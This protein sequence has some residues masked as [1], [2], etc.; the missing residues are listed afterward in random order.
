MK[1]AFRPQL[2]PTIFTIPSIIILIMLGTWQVERLQW[3]NSQIAEIKMKSNNPP[4][5]YLGEAVE[6]ETQQYM[7]FNLTGTFQHEKEKHLYTGPKTMKGTPGYNIF[8]PLLLENGESVLVDRGWVPKDKKSQDQR[9]ETLTEGITKITAMLHRGEKPGYFTPENDIK[10][11]LWFWAD[12]RLMLENNS[13]QDI[14]FREL[15][16]ISRKG[17]PIA[18][19]TQIKK[20]NDHL[21]Y[22]ITWYSLAIILLVIY[23][24]FH[25]RIRENTKN[26]QKR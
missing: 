3:K 23:V 7:L 22:A 18:G 21:Q 2:V 15:K 5:E 8:T 13:A 6:L 24:V 11:N 4:T 14:Y 9:P 19:E 26:H 20:R 12:V 17:I 10:Q 16:S 25:V 1:F